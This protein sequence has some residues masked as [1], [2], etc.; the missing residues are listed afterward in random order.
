MAQTANLLPRAEIAARKHSVVRQEIL[1]AAIQLFAAR[2]YRGVSLDDVAASLQYTK[3]VIYYYFK[4]KNEILWQIFTR[5]VEK[6]RVDI[7]TI[8]G[9][10]ERPDVALPL[11]IRAHA[12]NVMKN[13]ELTAIYWSEASELL[14]SQRQQL[15]R[16]NRNYDSMFESVYQRGV[17]EGIFRDIP[18]HVVVGGVLG[19]CNW[20]HTWYNERGS[21]SAD[22]I[23]DHFAELLS[24]GYSLDSR[25]VG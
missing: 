24:R 12:L 1:K 17:A 25:P 13:R 10:Y 16:M 20:L 21:L 23:A 9:Q 5:S 19:M 8:I 3:S 4:S 6:F 2:G 18:L 14:A 22:Q 7:E 11:M 15:N